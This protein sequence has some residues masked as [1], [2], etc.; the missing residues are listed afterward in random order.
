[1]INSLSRIL[2]ILLL[3]AIVAGCAS[4]PT[5]T[6]D[7]DPAFDFSGFQRIAILPVNRNVSPVTALSDMQVA[8]MN[9]SISDE[10]LR[11]GYSTTDEFEAADVFLTWHLVTQEV[12]DIRTYNT[13]SA[14]YTRC[15]QCSPGTSQNVRVRQFTQGTLIVDLID[16]EQQISVW[17]SI[18]E[19]R[20]RDHSPEEAAE[21]RRMAV[22]AIFDGFPPN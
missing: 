2:I 15:W 6:M 13:M 5:A 17:R 21:A 9:Q 16:P 3:P 18:L 12:T 10:L 20:M 11:R 4:T 14:R 8:R 22:E 19:S 1:M 7:Y